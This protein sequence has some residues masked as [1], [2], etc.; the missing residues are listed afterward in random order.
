MKNFYKK[1][2][3]L[4]TTLTLIFYITTIV[5]IKTILNNHSSLINDLP[6]ENFLGI[7]LAITGAGFIIFVFIWLIFEFYVLKL[8]NEIKE[9]LF[10]NDNKQTL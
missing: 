2:P 1:Y 8:I 4:A 3:N 10:K 6:F 9:I 7:S 5:F